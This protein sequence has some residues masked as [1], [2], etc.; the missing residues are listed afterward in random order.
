MTATNDNA[1]EAH[2]GGI[3]AETVEAVNDAINDELQIITELGLDIE[4]GYTEAVH[5][6]QNRDGCAQA[7]IT[8]LL[9]SGEVV[10]RVD[11]KELIDAAVDISKNFTEVT[12][13]TQRSLLDF[14]HRI[15]RLRNALS[16]FTTKTEGK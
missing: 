13:Y 12:C 14:K 5:Y 3:S 9:A 4:S 15:G 2:H 16:R 6:N 10:L 1:R 7:A 11:V 8:A